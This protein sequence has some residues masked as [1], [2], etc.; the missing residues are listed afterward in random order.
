M[1]IDGLVRIGW[2]SL[3][4][5]VLP[6]FAFS[7]KHSPEGDGTGQ[8]HLHRIPVRP[9]RLCRGSNCII[10]TMGMSM[11]ELSAE[12]LPAIATGW[13]VDYLDKLNV[14]MMQAIIS[15]GTQEEWLESS[16]GLGPIDTA[17]S[18]AL[19]EFDGRIISV[20][21]SFKEDRLAA[22]GSTAACGPVA[23]VR[24]QGRPGGVGGPAGH[25]VAGLGLK[26]NSEK[27]ASR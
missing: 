1:P 20:P 5:N 13:S 21:I 7:L 9:G 6:V 26:P 18:V 10:N 4:A 22:G 14:P 3:G 12:A 23:A 2:S 11:G 24:A 8:P 16:L 17:M 25:Q 19:P 15:T 27:N